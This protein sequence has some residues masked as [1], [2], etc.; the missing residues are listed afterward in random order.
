ME[1]HYNDKIFVNEIEALFSFFLYMCDFV[2]FFPSAQF[3]ARNRSS[4][5]NGR[6]N[7]GINAEPERI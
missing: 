4:Q 6:E 5:R 1:F 7:G 3:L 2:Y